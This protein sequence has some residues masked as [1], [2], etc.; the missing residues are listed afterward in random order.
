MD[1]ILIIGYGVVGKNLEK[2]LKP[3]SPDIIDKYKSEEN[4]ISQSAMENGYDLAFIV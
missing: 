4:K 3:L 1:N 2:E